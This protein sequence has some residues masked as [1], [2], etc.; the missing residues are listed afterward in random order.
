MYACFNDEERN[1]MK[2]I[3]DFL[4]KDNLKECCEEIV[5]WNRTGILKD[6][7]MRQLAVLTKVTNYPSSLMA[8][9]DLIGM[10]TISIFL[11]N[12]NK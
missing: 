3:D 4:T 5:E 12:F 10:K 11:D 2:E 6:G 7:K 9:R 1:I 8:A